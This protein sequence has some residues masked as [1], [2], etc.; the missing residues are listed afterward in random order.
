LRILFLTRQFPD[1]LQDSL[2]TGLR[3]LYGS[4]CIDYPRKD[5]LY[6]TGSPLYGRGFTIWSTPIADIERESPPFSNIDI[7]ICGSIQ[8]QWRWP[9]QALVRQP[10]AP[11]IAYLDGEDNTRVLSDLSPYFKRELVS[12]H[13]GVYP[14]G[15]GMPSNRIVELNVCTKTQMHQSH[16]VDPDLSSDTGHRFSDEAEYHSDLA[17][18]YFGITTRRGGWDCLRH[19]ELLAAG[20]L[21]MFKNYDTKPPLCAPICDCFV[22]YSGRED[23]ERVVNRLL[24]NGKPAQEYTDILTAQRRWLIENATCEARARHLITDIEGYY[25]EHPPTVQPMRWRRARLAKMRLLAAIDRPM[26]RA[27]VWGRQNRAIYGIYSKINR[28][29]NVY[30]FIRKFI[31][32]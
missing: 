22:S 13:E 17:R 20:A 32:E 11:R 29:I 14:I 19:Y 26:Y 27:T 2:L 9:W 10:N 23:F 5:I 21:V 7:V 8:R 15:F 12:P 16:V 28:H 4:D 24:P 18:S 31:I 1:N 25:R 30:D 3:A 6:G